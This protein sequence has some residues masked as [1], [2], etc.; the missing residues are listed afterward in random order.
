M[1]YFMKFLDKDILLAILDMDGTLID[2]T[3]IWAEIDK[4]FF[5][6][7]GFDS[8]PN[9]Y[10][11]TIVHMGLDKGAIM[12]V[13]RYGVP[14]DTPESV[15]KEWRDASIEQYEKYIQLKPYAKDFINY[16][17]NHNV[18]LA[19]AT[20]NDEEL[21]MP[22][23]KRLGID[24]D[25]DLIVDVNCVKQGKSSPAIYDYVI[26]KLNIKKENTIVVEDT[27]MG[28]KTAHDA[29]YTTIGVDDSSSR[30][31]ESEKRIYSDKYIY[32]FKEIVM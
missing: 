32:N 10:A 2:S 15:K 19:L 27:L 6:R 9:D 21:Y 1:K 23:L 28:L 20:A 17:K 31:I 30:H 5:A 18:L 25:F 26:N 7:R 3:G 4:D 14:G 24:K 8:V 13:E 12:T 29:G 11:Q 16:L 22:C